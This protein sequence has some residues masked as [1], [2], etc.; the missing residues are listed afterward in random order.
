MTTYKI[1]KWE[2]L[3]ISCM[4]VLLLMMVACNNDD[5]DINTIGYSDTSEYVGLTNKCDTV[6]VRI[7]NTDY[8]IV[9]Y[10]VLPFLSSLYPVYR[11]PCVIITNNGTLLVS[12]ENRE[13]SDDR[14]KIDII[15]ARRDKDNGCFE[16]RRVFKY[17][18]NSGRSM[19]PVFLYN[20]ATGRIYLFVCHLKDISKYA[21]DNSTDEID[22]VYKYSDD[23]GISWS[24]EYSLKGN[25][26]GN[27]Y[28]GIIPSSVKGITT[29]DGTLVL[30]TMVIK[31]N[32]WFSGLLLHR[33]DNWIFSK[34]TPNLGDNECTVY[35]DD[36]GR[37]VL[38][39]RTYENT[40]RRY[41]YDINNDSFT[42]TIP[43]ITPFNLAISTEIVN[44]NNCYYMCYPGSSD[45]HRSD[46]TLY[47]SNDGIHWNC[48]YQ[49][50]NGTTSD[51][52][53][54]SIAIGKGQ[55]YTVY[56]TGEGIFLQD[57]TPIKGV[58]NKLIKKN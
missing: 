51:F 7:D 25:W 8:R 5:N 20:E 38:D 23:D 9:E 56:E 54:T 22:F 42:E 48:I 47:G 37:L 57:L 52:G 35:L 21:R 43:P 46:L 3:R 31:N 50:M 16:I 33:D 36:K 24:D 26:N 15:I 19:N 12:C 30:P 34:A 49:M 14:G 45:V 17:N 10:T 29:T 27:E 53:Y 2:F 58:I 4:S 41:F 44:D 32:E 40:R 13:S 11:I 1:A 28:T 18:E 39:C 6:N 55:M